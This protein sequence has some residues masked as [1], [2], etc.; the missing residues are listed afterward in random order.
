MCG[1]N[2]ELFEQMNLFIPHYKKYYHY[3]KILLVF[4]RS[5]FRIVKTTEGDKSWLVIHKKSD[6]V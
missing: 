2:I 6:Y 3:V 4:N 1:L 5:N